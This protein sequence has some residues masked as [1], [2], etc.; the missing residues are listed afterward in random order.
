MFYIWFV[1]SII[2]SVFIARFVENLLDRL[3]H[4]KIKNPAFITIIVF[5]VLWWI[6][7]IV[8]NANSA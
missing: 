6:F 3:F 1:I 5:I 8:A 2:V 4:K 7:A